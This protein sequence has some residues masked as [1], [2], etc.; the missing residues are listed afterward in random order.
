MDIKTISFIGPSVWKNL[1]HSIKK[2][3][4]LNTF[5][6]NVKKHSNLNNECVSICEYVCVSVGVCIFY[7]CEFRPVCFPLPYPFSCLCVCVCVFFVVVAFSFTFSHFRSDLRDHNE[8]KAFLRV[9]CY[10]SHC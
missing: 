10:S 6:D 3:N 5:K 2:T 9:L 7:T 1:P 4:S 8:I